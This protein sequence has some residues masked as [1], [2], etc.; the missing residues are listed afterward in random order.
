MFD[1]AIALYAAAGWGG[2]NFDAIARAAG[3]GKAALYRR[4]ASREALFRETLEARWYAVQA[5]DTG[6]LR[7]DLLALGRMNFDALAGPFGEVGQHPAAIPA[8]STRCAP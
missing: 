6:T 7:G 1:A 8:C 2:F 3:V 4:W 5:I